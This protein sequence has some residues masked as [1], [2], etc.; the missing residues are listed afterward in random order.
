MLSVKTKSSGSLCFVSL[1]QDF[2]CS[3]IA[4]PIGTARRPADDFVVSN[5]PYASTRISTE[6]EP[7]FRSRC[8]HRSAH[9]S[10]ARKPDEAANLIRRASFS[11]EFFRIIARAAFDGGVTLSPASSRLPI[12]RTPF[13]TFT[14]TLSVSTPCFKMRLSVPRTRRVVTT[15]ADA[16][17]ISFLNFITSAVVSSDRVL[18]PIPFVNPT[19]LSS[20]GSI[21]LS[22]CC[23]VVRRYD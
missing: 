20:F 7:F 3:I 15:P 17:R 8:T 10:E 18:A 4:L 5:S 16:S 21:Q 13:A 23:F 12:T 2:N 9:C 6:T 19:A 1:F 14:P 11:S 22:M